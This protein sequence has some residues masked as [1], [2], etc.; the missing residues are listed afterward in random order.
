MEALSTPLPPTLRNPDS[1]RP[2]GSVVDDLPSSLLDCVGNTPLVTLNQIRTRNDITVLG[3]LEMQNPG[4]SIK[5]RTAASLLKNGIRKGLINPGTKI[6]ESSSGNLGISLAQACCQLGLALTIVMD[7]RTNRNVIK[8]VELYGAT[9]EMVSETRDGESLLDARLRR[10]RELTESDPQVYWLNQ[11]E[12][13]ANPAA[14]NAT[15][16]E[17]IQQTHGQFDRLYIAT[18]TC[19]TLAGCHDHLRKLSMDPQLV[20]VDMIG[21]AI[22]Q[23]E[24]D[25]TMIES[26]LPGHGSSRH[27]SFLN[28]DDVNEVAFVSDRECVEGCRF[29]LQQ[30]GILAG[31]TSGGI[32]SAFR[33]DEPSLPEGSTVVLLLCDRGERYLDTIYDEDWVQKTLPSS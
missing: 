9:V 23:P 19:G 12:N 11:Y 7:S 6:V 10:V 21:S 27:S 16:R 22:F 8:L 14:H 25:A 5:D 18:S 4:G 26:H 3:K 31:G 17:I 24:D 2:L 29:L 20:A 13:P 28:A 32:V 30:E 1:S 15:M 33:K